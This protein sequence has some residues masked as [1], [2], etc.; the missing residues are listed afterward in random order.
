[1]IGSRHQAPA[2]TVSPEEAL[3]KLLRSYERYYDINRESPLAPFAAEAS[4]SAHG[5]QYFLI[6]SAKWAEIDSHEFIYFA[7]E[8]ELTPERVEELCGLAWEDGL[9][10][11]D[12]KPNHRNSDV[13]PFIVCRHM[14]PEAER[15]ARA[16]KKS[17]SYRFGLWGW[18][19][20]KLAVLEAGSG[21][22]AANRHGKPLLSLIK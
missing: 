1:M 4:F 6:K 2:V 20:F 7:L 13:I 18:S 3:E 21:K 12:P 14:T 17:V 8:Q 15:R 11:A 9:K 16:V 22:T 19:N 5:E 10:K